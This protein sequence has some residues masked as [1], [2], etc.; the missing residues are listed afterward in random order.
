MF[1]APPPFADTRRA[2]NFSQIFEDVRARIEAS[3]SVALISSSSHPWFEGHFPPPL[4]N[5]INKAPYLVH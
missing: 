1:I 3:V 4:I 2:S 5:N